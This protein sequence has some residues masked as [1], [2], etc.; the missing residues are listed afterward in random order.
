[1]RDRILTMRSRNVRQWYA[2]DSFDAQCASTATLPTTDVSSNPLPWLFYTTDPRRI[3]FQVS[4]RN[5]NFVSLFCPWQPTLLEIKS[6]IDLLLEITVISPFWISIK[7]NGDHFKHFTVT[8]KIL[9]NFWIWHHIMG[10]FRC[11]ETLVA[12]CNQDFTLLSGQIDIASSTVISKA[13]KTWDF[14]SMENI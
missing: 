3:F 13:L 1:M 12:D 8:L 2:A 9:I 11:L 14:V 10:N 7:F 4:V 6:T 5:N